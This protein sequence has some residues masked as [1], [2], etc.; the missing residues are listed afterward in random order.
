MSI[1]KPRKFCKLRTDKH[2]S[3][4]GLVG[5]WLMNE[6]AG[7]KVY[8]LSGNRYNGDFVN[9][10]AWT[11][12][13]HGTA[14][15]LDGSDDYVNIGDVLKITTTPLSIVAWVNTTAYANGS[16]YTIVSKGETG[17]NRAYWLRL[18]GT[19]SNCRIRFGDTE[20]YI[21]DSSG[22]GALTPNQWYQVSGVFGGGSDYRVYRNGYQVIVSG[23]P[24]GGFDDS[25]EPLCIG[26][27]FNDSVLG[28]PFEGKISH[29][30]IFNRA[31]SATE[32]KQLY[33]EPFCMFWHDLIELWSKEGAAAAGDP[34]IMTLNTGY[35]GPTYNG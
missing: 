22:I 15:I 35:W 6:G 4:D 33:L 31:L 7:D 34:G 8:D 29:V 13:K 28:Y 5:C 21:Y 30:Y 9:E 25:S 3:V 20:G 10:T 17:G 18:Y 2:W 11:V 16:N 23:T 19:G 26:A 32:I 27:E 24:S 14:L 1:R 12:G